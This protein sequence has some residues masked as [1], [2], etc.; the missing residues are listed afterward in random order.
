MTTEI[1]R[2]FR[3]A[4][5]VAALLALADMFAIVLY[6]NQST[7]NAGNAA[8]AAL[9]GDLIDLTIEQGGRFFLPYQ[10][11]Y[12]DG[13]LQLA[14]P[15]IRAF[16]EKKKQYDPELLLTNTFYERY[17]RLGAAPT[18]S[19]KAMAPADSAARPEGRSRAAARP[20]TSGP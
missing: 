8:M 18:R 1:V 16:F 17:S 2:R 20:S 5:I 6:L 4:L 12:T 13:Q 9:T 10:L 14:Y 19:Q 3:R 7:D 15:E 11:H